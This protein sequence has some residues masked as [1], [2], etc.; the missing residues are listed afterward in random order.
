M[1]RPLTYKRPP[2]SILLKLYKSNTD[3]AI[4]AM[5][6][7]SESAVKKWRV[8]YNIKGIS[9]S[10]GGIGA[11][12][13]YERPS[14]EE[15]RTLTGTKTDREIA[16]L[17]GCTRTAVRK[18]RNAYDLKKTT[19]IYRRRPWAFE[20]D[21]DF[22]EKIDTEQKAYIL[23]LLATD[24]CVSN[25]KSHANRVFLS[26][27]AR[28][29]HIL[30]EVLQAMRADSP[31]HD[32]PKG[33]FPGSGPMKYIAVTSRKLVSDLA[34]LGIVPRKSMTLAYTN[35]SRRLERHYVRGLFDGDG[36]IHGRGGFYFLGTE[37][38]IDGIIDAIYRHTAIRLKKAKAGRLYRASGYG[39]SVKVLHWMYRRSTIHLHR[40]MK[41]YE[42]C[43]A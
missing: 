42:E 33:S 2:R 20:L 13:R 25:N 7:C 23:G 40:K 9:R 14:K 38:L 28:D 43:Y 21:E 37:F 39:G 41:I 26:L 35:I 27:Q 5:F 29:E 3:E 1:P 32:R 15:L 10:G 8:R 11:K 30:R 17:Y 36:C 4:A 6:G 31:V 18:W 19:V 24:G 12:R 22:F 34:R 16:A